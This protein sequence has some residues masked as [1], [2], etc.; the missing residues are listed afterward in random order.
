MS[1]KR[2]PTNAN[3]GDTRV[4]SYAQMN[5]AGGHT[6][7]AGELITPSNMRLTADQV[8]QSQE[9]KAKQEQEKANAEAAKKALQSKYVSK[10]GSNY[11]AIRDGDAQDLRNQRSGFGAGTRP[12]SNRNQPRST[13]VNVGGVQQVP[14]LQTQITQPTEQ[15]QEITSP[16]RPDKRF[17][18]GYNGIPPNV[19]T[20]PEGTRTAPNFMIKVDYEHVITED[21]QK[22]LS[23]LDNIQQQAQGQF[24][25]YE[26]LRATGKGLSASNSLLAANEGLGAAIVVGGVLGL[27]DLLVKGSTDPLGAVKDVVETPYNIGAMLITVGASE[28]KLLPGAVGG[29]VYSALLFNRASGLIAPEIGVFKPKLDSSGNILATEFRDPFSGK[30]TQYTTYKHLFK[31]YNKALGDTGSALRTEFFPAS[32]L[33]EGASIDP[34]GMY[35]RTS[36]GKRAGVQQSKAQ[37]RNVASGNVHGGKQPYN[38]QKITQTSGGDVN[39]IAIQRALVQRNGQ[40][41]AIY[42]EGIGGKDLGSLTVGKMIKTGEGKN[43]VFGQRPVIAADFNNNKLFLQKES[44]LQG[45]KLDKGQS[46]PIGNKLLSRPPSQVKSSNHVTSESGFLTSEQKLKVVTKESIFKNVNPKPLQESPIYKTNPS[47]GAGNQIPQ[48]ELVPNAK[49]KSSSYSPNSLTQPIMKGGFRYRKGGERVVQVGKSSFPDLSGRTNKGQSNGESFYNPELQEPT[50]VHVNLIEPISLK[51]NELVV[52]K[53]SSSALVNGEKISYLKDT[54]KLRPGMNVGVSGG[55]VAAQEFHKVSGVEYRQ[56]IRTN[57]VV[58]S[59]H[60]N[61][62][63]QMYYAAS[64]PIIEQNNDLVTDNVSILDVG[65]VAKLNSVQAGKVG[66]VQNSFYKSKQNSEQ[67]SKADYVHKPIQLTTPDT[68]PFEYMKPP[69]GKGGRPYERTKDKEPIVPETPNKPFLSFKFPDNSG[70]EQYSVEVGK[71]G[72]KYYYNLGRGGKELIAKGGRLARNTA[73]ASVKV[74]PLSRGSSTND[75][76]SFLGRDLFPSKNNR[77]VQPSKKR[78]SSSG[79][80]EQIPGASHKNILMGGFKKATLLQSKGLS[81]RKIRS[82][83]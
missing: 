79:E 4:S 48:Y 18:S 68:I 51:K 37:M 65:S 81:L 61:K 16:P 22:P 55:V 5:Q 19:S 74:V 77:Y 66:T 80:K 25:K 41:F 70:G 21:Q 57:A 3:P 34:L 45:M 14:G 8:R 12:V 36:S 42:E 38:Y 20:L 58:F 32:K 1:G 69:T 56:N 15:Q 49:A 50:S 71:P 23:M 63:K 43:V 72:N 2:T 76:K 53:Q 31:D 27:K 83:L 67:I 44:L 7:A 40:K 28:P 54:S 73:A 78:I 6:Q 24:T 39:S 26:M 60:K 33:G 13:G 10:V 35:A 64:V 29:V 82:M 30:P 46:N 59:E 52:M 47:V 75:I 62:D 9:A 11:Y 17:A